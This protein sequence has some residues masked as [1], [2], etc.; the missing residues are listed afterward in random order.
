MKKTIKMN[1]DGREVAVQAERVGSILTVERD[2]ESYSVE[3]VEEKSA[4]PKPAPKPRP[5]AAQTQTTPAPAPAPA[6]P[7]GGSG[8]VPA[9]MTG[10]IKEILVSQGGTVASGDQI[11]MMEAMKMDIEVA[12]PAAGTVTE[13]YVKPGDSIKENQP[14]MKI[15]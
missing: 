13:I 3:L 14:L 11:I 10:T 4:T 9:P 15:E 5:A 2:G 1:I 12:A 7:A 6:V 8:T